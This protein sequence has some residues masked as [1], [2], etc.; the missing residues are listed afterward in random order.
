MH[1]CQTTT[2]F[3]NKIK[4]ENVFLVE[5][6]KLNLLSV[7]QTCEQGNICIFDSEKC[8]IKNKE[9]DPNLCR[10]AK[11][12]TNNHRNKDAVE[13]TLCFI[14]QRTETCL[15]TEWK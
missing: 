5:N 4:E 9:P 12:Y 15:H 13:I 7:S 14:N 8:E 2:I 6:L 10:N 3:N 11:E 1:I